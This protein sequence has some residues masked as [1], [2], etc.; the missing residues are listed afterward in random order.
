MQAPAGK[1]E[2]LPGGLILDGLFSRRLAEFAFHL[3]M[4]SIARLQ[5]HEHQFGCDQRNHQHC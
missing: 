1:Y 2:S 4:H 5:I 3:A